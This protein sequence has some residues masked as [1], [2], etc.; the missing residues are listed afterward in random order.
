MAGYYRKHTAHSPDVRLSRSLGRLGLVANTP[1]CHVT[2][3]LFS[4]TGR[5]V[6][7][8][9]F[10]DPALLTACH[11]LEFLVANAGG[12]NRIVQKIGVISDIDMDSH[13]GLLS[14]GCVSGMRIGVELSFTIMVYLPTNGLVRS[15]RGNTYEYVVQIGFVFSWLRR[16]LEVFGLF[17]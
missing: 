8:G 16:S 7:P 14:M 15:C 10:T 17:S 5:S 3:E 4:H 11:S 9:R 1:A 12:L 13:S 6:I 2:A